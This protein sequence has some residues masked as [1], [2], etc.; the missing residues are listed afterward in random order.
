MSTR[1]KWNGN[2]VNLNL[3]EGNANI[4]N[5]L[6]GDQNNPW[7]SYSSGYRARVPILGI[8]EKSSV[9][10]FL[11][12]SDGDI[13]DLICKANELE[14]YSNSDTEASGII[15]FSANSS[16]T[17]NK[18]FP[19]GKLTEEEIE[20]IVPQ[21]AERLHIRSTNVQVNG[22]PREVIEFLN[23]R[24]V[25]EAKFS[26]QDCSEEEKEANKESNVTQK[27]LVTYA[28]QGG[29][30]ED[31][32]KVDTIYLNE[33]DFPVKGITNGVEWNIDWEGFDG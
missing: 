23:V 19:V 14:F 30:M 8:T 9:A 20:R 3:N 7:E 11:D 17:E 10:C 25:T 21:I 5:F 4:A 2:W 18:I 12:K 1:V 31:S 32:P 29:S 24:Q 22:Q 33:N 16:L 28:L 15:L 27:I 6:V 26:R 13:T